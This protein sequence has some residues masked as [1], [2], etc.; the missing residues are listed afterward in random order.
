[1]GPSPNAWDR[2]RRR[3]D[4]GRAGP[5]L[6]QGST[7]F[8][9]GE[10]RCE[11][12]G[13]Q[14]GHA[15]EEKGQWESHKRCFSNG[16]HATCSESWRHA[17]VPDSGR[18]TCLCWSDSLRATSRRRAE[19]SEGTNRS[20]AGRLTRHVHLLRSRPPVVP[21]L[22]DSALDVRK[23]IQGP[24]KPACAVHGTASYLLRGG[25]RSSRILSATSPRSIPSSSR[26]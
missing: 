13:G 2:N 25:E 24:W 15:R 14:H 4:Y 8:E 18:R 1:M 16:L 11:I 22:I 26:R 23:C 12:A 10:D 7:V 17:S 3:K 9:I 6:P 5:G 21:G 19:R 20:G